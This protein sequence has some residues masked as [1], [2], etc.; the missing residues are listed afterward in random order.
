[1]HALANKEPQPL[2]P[3]L[4]HSPSTTIATT[5][6]LTPNRRSL[7]CN[8]QLAKQHILRMVQVQNKPKAPRRATLPTPA[9]RFSPSSAFEATNTESVTSNQLNIPAVSFKTNEHVVQRSC[10]TQDCP[11]VQAG[12][13]HDEGLFKDGGLDQEYKFSILFGYVD[14]P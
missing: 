6:Y 11:L 9:L 12:I 14:T 4:F 8:H 7:N 2:T 5:P 3:S 1:M 13:E 10:T